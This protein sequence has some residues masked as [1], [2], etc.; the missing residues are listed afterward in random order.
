MTVIPDDVPLEN[1][2]CGDEAPVHTVEV[3][4]DIVAIGKDLTVTLVDFAVL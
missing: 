4:A 2:T 1:V 3:L